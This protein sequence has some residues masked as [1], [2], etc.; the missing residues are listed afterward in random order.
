MKFTREFY[1]AI[2]IGAGIIAFKSGCF[3]IKKR[4]REHLIAVGCILIAQ[5]AD[6]I[7][8]AENFLN[9]DKSALARA[10]G[11]NVIDGDLCTVRHWHCQH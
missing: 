11:F 10:F 6:M 5:L 7:G 9:E 2:K 3:A 8:N 4:G 1:R